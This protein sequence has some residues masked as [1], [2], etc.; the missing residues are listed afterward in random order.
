M[1]E[2]PQHILVKRDYCPN[3]FDPLGYIAFLMIGFQL[4]LNIREAEKQVQMQQAQES[5]AGTEDDAA[6][7]LQ[8]QAQP[9]VPGAGRLRGGEGRQGA[10]AGDGEEVG[11]RRTAGE[12]A[13]GKRAEVYFS[14]SRRGGLLGPVPRLLLPSVMY[15]GVRVVSLPVLAVVG[16]ADVLSPGEDSTL[17]WDR[18]S[19]PPSVSH[20]RSGLEFPDGVVGRASSYASCPKQSNFSYF[21]FM[22]MMLIMLETLAKGVR[23]YD[24]APPADEATDSAVG[25]ED[26]DANHAARGEGRRSRGQR[27]VQEQSSPGMRSAPHNGCLCSPHDEENDPDTED[28]L[29]EEHDPW[30]LLSTI[31][32]GRKGA[33]GRRGVGA[34]V[35]AMAGWIGWLMT[36]QHCLAWLQCEI[37]GLLVGYLGQNG[38]EDGDIDERVLKTCMHKHTKCPLLML[39]HNNGSRS[40]LKIKKES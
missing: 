30:S 19:P 39:S 40:V 29:L 32:G 37:R 9:G 5:G 3:T 31:D 17:L 8:Q 7:P 25:G 26:S 34:S 23:K 27:G 11:R 12:A 4:T 36:S 6:E 21:G 22:N 16:A 24:R 33:E 35:K 10:S 1:E 20:A 13:G 14:T 15:F 28:L 18:A 38:D 2:S